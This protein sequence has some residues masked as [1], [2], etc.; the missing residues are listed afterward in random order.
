MELIIKFLEVFFW[1]IYFLGPLLIILLSV[2]IAFGQVVGRW[3]KWSRFDAL[4]WS[5][6]TASTVGYG[7]IRP[8]RRR[9]KVLSIL[10]AVMGIILTGFIVAI[11]VNAAT[12]A[13]R[14]NE[15]IQALQEARSGQNPEVQ[16][17]EPD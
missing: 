14:E 2:V 1:A 3:E 17:Q 15:E 12:A 13:L 6:I 5:L 7:D 10:I 16:P 8:T 9:S 4:Y 11:S